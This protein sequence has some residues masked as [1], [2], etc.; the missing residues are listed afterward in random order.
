MALK[1]GDFIEVKTDSRKA[2]TVWEKLIA[3]DDG[4]ISGTRRY[5]LVEALNEGDICQVFK[6]TGP[7][8][9]TAV[10]KVC[11][12]QCDNDLVENEARI[13][14]LINPATAKEE[15]F[16]RYIPKVIDSFDWEGF[17]VNVLT[18]FAEWI[19]LAD[20]LKA[21]PTG[22]DFKDA[23]WMFKR[24]LAG[25]GFAHTRNIIHGAVLPPHILVHPVQHG[26]K[27]LDWSYAVKVGKGHIPAISLDYTAYYPPEVVTKGDPTPATDIFMMAK[28]AVALIGGDVTTNAMPNT[29]PQSVQD[30]LLDCLQEAPRM[31]PQNAWDLHENF[32]KLLALVVGK[33]KYRPFTMPTSA[34]P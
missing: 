3:D 7:N 34:S 10:I 2:K 29:V 31:R 23:A 1:V 18:Y 21:Y 33:S 8:A 12:F 16:Y 25:V 32:D 28:C 11:R 6:A 9:E 20:I 26:A 30:F 22:I 13:L 24:M 27:I 15:A 17:R 4:I 14:N 19:S 5:A